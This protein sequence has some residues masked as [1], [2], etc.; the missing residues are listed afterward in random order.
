MKYLTK[1]SLMFLLGFL[2]SVSFIGAPALPRTSQTPESTP[3]IT[4]TRTEE[5]KAKTGGNIPQANIPMPTGP[6]PAGP[7]CLDP[8]A[9]ISYNPSTNVETVIPSS[10]DAPLTQ[11]IETFEGFEGEMDSWTDYESVLGTD[12]RTII[13]T[14]TSFP[15]RTICKIYIVHPNG[16]RGTGTGFL[17]DDFHV[18]TAGH[19]AYL[20]D[21]VGWAYD[22]WASQ[23][24]VIPAMDSY[25]APYCHAQFTLARSYT[26][27]TTSRM[28]EHDWAMLTLDRNIGA[29]VGYMGRQ[30]AASSDPIYT[31][32]LNS[33][34]YPGDL[35][36]GQ[37][38]YFDADSGRTATEY[39]H[40]YY[41]DTGGGQSGMPIWR[42]SGGNRYVLTVHAYGNDG[43]NSNHGTRF[44][45]D[46]YDRI[47]EWQ[48]DDVG[49]EPA[50]NPDLVDHGQAHSLRWDAVDPDYSEIYGSFSPSLVGDGVTSFTV[51][52]QVDNWGAASSGFYV[53]FYASTNTI[54]SGSD[55][56]IGQTWVSSL[57]AYSHT[58]V[59]WSGTFPSGAP[60]GNYYVGW[61]IDASSLITE[62][63]EGNNMGVI[64]STQVTVD[65]NHPTAPTSFISNPNVDTWSIDNTIWV[66]WWGDTDVGSGVAGYGLYW[67]TNPTGTPAQTLDT[68][69]SYTTSNVLSDSDSW[70]LHIIT[71][72]AA[73]NWSP[74][75]YHIGPFK[76][77]TIGPSTVY[78]LQGTLG[79]NNWYVTLVNITLTPTDAGSGVAATYY[80]INSTSWQ[81]YTGMFNLSLSGEY[82]IEYYSLDALNNPETNKFL[83]IDVDLVDPTSSLNAE[84]T[85]VGGW[86]TSNANITMTANDPNSGI[87]NIT[88][89]IDGGV[90]QLY[91]GYFLISTQ[92]AHTVEY[93][94]WDQAGNN[95]TIHSEIIS[96]DFSAPSWVQAP[97]DQLVPPGIP[98]EYDL[99][100]TDT[101]SGI[102]SWSV[103]NTELFSINSQGTITNVIALAAGYYGV[104]VT[105]TDIAGHTLVGTFQV[106][107]QAPPI[108]GFPLAA[109][110][111]GAITALGLGIITRRRQQPRKP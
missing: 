40:W 61:L 105:V 107:Q 106:Q 30:T 97:T 87:E 38:M 5:T 53:R 78:S 59:S 50:N 12:D 82:T 56:L 104:E 35:D 46:K 110:A 52:T 4:I 96:L 70:Y 69:V 13:S 34:G 66:D 33:A 45:T 71:V 24:T 7:V 17:I 74:D 36:N 10:H 55:Y 91:T 93:H 41:M 44:N 27:W 108:P 22:A 95:E 65:A 84:G 64:T 6:I 100:A 15:W 73:G 79:D 16:D 47:I 23:L 2:I 81:T 109:I 51:A 90:W 20:H 8:T 72:D 11:S 39:N 83:Y 32:T 18:L 85:L 31:G 60:S 76:I 57:G 37:N 54:I 68:V 98:F 80:R 89:R 111:I 1:L 75:V 48:G 14:T 67:S 62:I 43:S 101:Y 26:G 42:I 25:Y 77:D 28:H 102:A 19:V 29:W 103:N 9:T 49:S 21:E 63:D 99:N 88:Y 3:K 94:A 92:G 86:F 58:T